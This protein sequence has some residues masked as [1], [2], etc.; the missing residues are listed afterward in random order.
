MSRRFDEPI[1]VRRRDDQPAEFRWRGRRYVIRAV[2][3]SW[4][5]TG[6]WWRS[7]V[8]QGVYGLGS[9]GGPEP[10]GSGGGPEGAVPDGGGAPVGAPVAIPTGLALD[11][12]ERELWRVEASRGRAGDVGTFDLSFDWSAGRWRLVQALD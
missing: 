5:E 3:A 12:T 1:E 10:P 4:V 11:E 9:G 8:A 6:A 2:L 7:P